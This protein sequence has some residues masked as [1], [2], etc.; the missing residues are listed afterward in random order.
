MKNKM[1]LMALSLVCCWAKAA[2][3]GITE[4]RLSSNEYLM[5]YQG[6][7]F[8][9]CGSN[10][11]QCTQMK[12]P[13]AVTPVDKL[14]AI[15]NIDG[16]RA[17]WLAYSGE[18][19]FICAVLP[20]SVQVNCGRILS[21][22]QQVQSKLN[23]KAKNLAFTKALGETRSI[24]AG[25]LRL[26]RNHSVWWGWE[27]ACNECEDRN[28]DINEDFND[29]GEGAAD[30]EQEANEACTD[31][32]STWTASVGVLNAKVKDFAADL[33]IEFSYTDYAVVD[34]GTCSGNAASYYT[35][36]TSVCESR[37]TSDITAIKNGG[38]GNCTYK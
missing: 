7:Y 30:A 19:T 3:S 26:A 9:L 37:K 34:V 32:G 12:M 8:K 20:N 36:L 5:W 18:K 6:Q 28:E 29:C 10:K 25:E 33:A 4:I 27:T 11:A 13:K 1:L 35:K 16:A 14:A 38:L 31:G 21:Q 23:A 15:Q 24:L 17:T 2:D 22:R